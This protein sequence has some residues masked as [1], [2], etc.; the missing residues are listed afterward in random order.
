MR[1]LTFIPA[2]GFLSIMLFAGRACAQDKAAPKPFI[3]QTLYLNIDKDTPRENL[4]SLLKIWKERVM[5][6]NPYFVSTKILRHFWGHDSREVL[7]MFELKSW[8]DIP[9]AFDR[10]DQ[11][12]K[13]HEGWASEEDLKKFGEMWRNAFRGGHHADEIYSVVS[14]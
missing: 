9:K 4:D 1:R 12:L 2:I 3:I 5:D 10:R 14:E 11:I 6:V 8:D 7:F 13:A